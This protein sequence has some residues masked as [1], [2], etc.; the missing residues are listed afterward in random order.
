MD[1]AQ[2]PL[3]KPTQP[4]KCVYKKKKKNAN[5]NTNNQY[6]NTRLCQPKR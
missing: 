6:Q 1:N 3:E 2:D 4:Q 5:A